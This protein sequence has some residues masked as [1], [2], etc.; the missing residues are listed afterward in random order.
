MS[1]SVRAVIIRDPLTVVLKCG[2]S[3]GTSASLPSNR[4]PSFVAASRP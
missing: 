2:S 4:I 3:V 1:P